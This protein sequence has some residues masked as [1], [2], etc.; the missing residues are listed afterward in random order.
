MLAAMPYRAGS[1]RP[2]RFVDYHPRRLGVLVLGNAWLVGLCVA[3]F[4]VSIESV[5]RVLGVLVMIGSTTQLAVMWMER[6]RVRL[7]KAGGVVVVEHRRWPLRARI[8]SYA[9]HEVLDVAVEK[10]PLR[11]TGRL[12]LVLAGGRKAPLTPTY[13]G[14]NARH[15]GAAEEIRE[16]LSAI[17]GE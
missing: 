6:L 3:G 15:A 17:E 16:L 7:D 11:Q 5:Y 12:S 2:E 9:L 10:S 4:I 8:A 13:F 14:S 1:P